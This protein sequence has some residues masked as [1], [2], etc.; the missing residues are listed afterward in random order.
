MFYLL[1]NYMIIF[2]FTIRMN[3]TGLDVT[4]DATVTI[5]DERVETDTNVLGQQ[6]GIIELDSLIRGTAHVYSPNSA[7]KGAEPCYAG[8]S[9]EFNSGSVNEIGADDIQPSGGNITLGAYYGSMWPTV[10]DWW[11]KLTGFKLVICNNA[12][13]GSEMGCVNGDTNNWTATG[14]NRANS[15]ANI[16]L[17][18]TAINVTKPKAFFCCGLTN[19]SRSSVALST[20]QAGINSYI[21][22]RQLKYPG[23]PIYFIN[24]KPV[25]GFETRGNTLRQYLIDAVAAHSNCYIVADLNDFAAYF[26]PGDTLH[27]TQDGNEEVAH[28]MMSNMRTLGL[29]P[30]S[31]ITRTPITE[32][33]TVLARMTTPSTGDTNMI[34]DFVNY[35]QRKSYLSILKSFEFYHMDSEVNSLQD[36]FRDKDVTLG[37]GADWN[38]DDGI[39]LD[40]TTN[41]YIR[42]N[43]FPLTDNGGV[44]SSNCQ[45]LVWVRENNNSGVNATLMGATGPT[46]THSA[47]M[48]QKSDNTSLEWSTN[49]GTLST[50]ATGPFKSNIGYGP[51]KDATATQKFLTVTAMTRSSGSGATTVAYPPTEVYIGVHNNNGTLQEPFTG[52]ISAF[53]FTQATVS[54]SFAATDMVYKKIR[55]MLLAKKYNLY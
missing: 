42:T 35:M 45:Y 30:G 51:C 17:A 28:Y 39:T 25:A 8:S 47:V 40:G 55:A 14:V 19:D 10:A 11:Y 43:F 37:S 5:T 46:S 15:D 26:D 23:V 21:E 6:L 53:A 16:D 22:D 52:K 13:G 54:G 18:M 44:T 1:P 31:P 41:G 48:R 12:V 50:S 36:W 29:L 49:N 24:F 33:S 3:L 9:F 20:I 34:C 32:A 4:T 27:M 2:N 7:D 38:I